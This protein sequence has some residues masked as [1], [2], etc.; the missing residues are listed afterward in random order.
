[1]LKQDA[2]P[3]LASKMGVWTKEDAERELG[4]PSDRRDAIANNAVFGDIYKF[5]SPMPT[6]ATIEISVSRKTNKVQAAYFYYANLVPWKAVEDKLGKN[7]QQQ[8]MANGRP[9]YIYTFQNRQL[10][11]LVDS[12]DNVA[13]IG[14][15]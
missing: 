1:L 5:T 7:Y 12:A 6:F 10:S 8:T 15:W 3:Y 13:S 4:Q 11:V 2:I 14:L 9:M